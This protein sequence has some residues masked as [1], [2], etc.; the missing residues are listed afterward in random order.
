MKERF[1]TVLV[2]IKDSDATFVSS[3]PTASASNVNV[4]YKHNGV[5]KRSTLNT[6]TGQYEY[7]VVKDREFPYLGE[8][9]E[10]F[11]FS[12]DATRMGNAPMISAQN[13]M[14]YAKNIYIFAYLF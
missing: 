9:M 10:I 14:W 1:L 4:I 13:V 8:P 6:S 11:D 12:Y 7:V 5:Y 2:P 3:L